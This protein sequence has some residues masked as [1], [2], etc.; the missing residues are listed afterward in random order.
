MEAIFSFI[1]RIK[2][3]SCLCNR[4]SERVG[5][6]RRSNSYIKCSGFPPFSKLGQRWLRCVIG[7]LKWGERFFPLLVRDSQMSKQ[8]LFYHESGH[9]LQLLLLDRDTQ[10]HDPIDV[11]NSCFT[12]RAL[13]FGVVDRGTKTVLGTNS[14]LYFKILKILFG[15]LITGLVGVW[16]R[17]E[18]TILGAL[19][20]WRRIPRAH[21]GLSS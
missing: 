17:N 9:V 13:P 1:C 14:K 16:Q 19:M 15:A 20:Q 7:F 5:L 18:Y 2:R 11:K 21:W 12:E 3:L 6:E 10:W 4:I 8:T